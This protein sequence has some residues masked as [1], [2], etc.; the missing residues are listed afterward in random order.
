SR[1]YR[2]DASAN[3]QPYR[4]VTNDHWMAG[5]TIT[6]KRYMKLYVYLPI[7]LRPQARDALLISFGVGSTA[8]ALADTASLR[9]I[10][11]VDISRDILDLSTVVYPG[12]DNPLRDERVHVTIEDGRFF[13]STTTRRYDLITS[14]P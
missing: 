14:Q 2:H 7:A 11:V 1:Y 3:P 4:L 10:D 6:S 9:R 5:T 8:K 13:L 12:A